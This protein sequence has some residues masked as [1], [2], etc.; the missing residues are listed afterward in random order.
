MGMS[1]NRWSIGLRVIIILVVLP[2]ILVT[3]CGALIRLYGAS[4]A[5]KP[6]GRVDQLI[7]SIVR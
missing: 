4:I 5:S 3:F 1:G 2:Q 7:G 6:L